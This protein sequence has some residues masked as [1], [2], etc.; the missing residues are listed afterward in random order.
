MSKPASSSRRD[1]L[2]A[3]LMTTAL[4]GAEGSLRASETRQAAASAGKARNVI[5]MVSDGMNHGALS[6]SHLYRKHFDQ[7]SIHW[8]D[9]YRER[10]VVRA[11]AETY[12][13]NSI[14][15]DSSAAASAW[16][17]GQRVNNGTLN[18][19]TDGKPIRTLHQKIQEKGFKT[20]LVSTAT[21]T[22]ATPAGFVVNMDSRGEEDA[23]AQQYLER[24]VDVLLGGG[25]KFFKP[26]LRA[27]Y[28]STGYDV[29][30]TRNALLEL[31]HDKLKP[32]LGV[33]YDSHVPFTID[34]D[35][36]KS[37]ADIVPTLAEMSQVALD[38]LSKAANGFFLMIEGARIDHAGHQNDAA[39][40]VHDQ[41]AFDDAIGV[42]LKFIDTHPDTLLIITTDH[43]CGGIQTNG[44][45][46]SS[47]QGFA[48]GIYNAST[49]FFEHIH[50][51]TH[52]FEWMKQ[53]KLDGLN[54]PKLGEA[55][56]KYTGFKLTAEQ[57]KEMQ[58]MKAAQVGKVMQNYHGI[59]WTSQN[60]TGELVEFCAYGPG[61]NLFPSFVE[62]RQVHD[63]VLRAMDVA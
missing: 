62:N 13:A 37:L 52:S 10:P 63:L 19:S 60:H 53:Q 2:R 22:H 27:Q 16:G 30:D 49:P 56:E 21:I 51:I 28:A 50:T 24:R 61:S 26:E 48:P 8:F 45:S 33:F 36:D 35:H 17:G 34:R 41:L 15:T 7:K 46:K 14:V 57:I 32:L 9:L 58:G 29:A 55:V 54:G 23:I 43:G 44:I 5:F 25:Q 40:S 18:I 47:G 4:F 12:S 31:S 20:G 3:S 39:A 6:L 59:G 38:R 42:A 1:F 11:L